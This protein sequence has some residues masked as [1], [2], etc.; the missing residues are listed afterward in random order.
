MQLQDM[1]HICASVGALATF[2]SLIYL[3]YKDS[4]KSKT[5]SDLS[6]IAKVLERD[7]ELKYQPH[8]WLNGVQQRADENKINFDIN[9]KGEWCNLLDFKIIKGDLILDERNKHLPYELEPIFNENI[10]TDTT[11]R[12]IFTINNSEKPISEV[13]YE[14]EIVYENRIRQKFFLK[15]IGK[16]AIA[17]LTTPKRK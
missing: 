1:F 11:R 3:F 10:I 13:E 5:I 14:I 8:L 9:N 6:K 7:L 17:K 12:W 2:F 15:I 16:G 4:K